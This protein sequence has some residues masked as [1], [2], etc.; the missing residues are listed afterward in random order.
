MD[1]YLL[2][3]EEEKVFSGI[4]SLMRSL[5]N[6]PSQ[7]KVLRKLAHEMDREVIRPGQVRAAAAAARGAAVAQSGSKR[8]SE[9]PSAEKKSKGEREADPIY[10]KWASTPDGAFLVQNHKALK[11]QLA[12]IKDVKSEAFLLKKKEV[13]TASSKMRESLQSFRTAQASLTEASEQ[14]KDQ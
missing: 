9:N 2:S 6:A 10:K 13:A 5:K 12:L 4:A 3:E 8:N 1:K 14:K 7:H 11:D